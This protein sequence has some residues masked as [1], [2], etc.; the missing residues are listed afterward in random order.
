M[1]ESSVS[2]PL[3]SLKKN[4]DVVLD[5]IDVTRCWNYLFD[6]DGAALGNTSRDISPVGLDTSFYLIQHT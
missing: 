2:Q 3:Y 6:I 1:V 4:D 5:E